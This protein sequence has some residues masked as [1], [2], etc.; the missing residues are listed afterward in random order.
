LLLTWRESSEENLPIELADPVE[1]YR[2][3][4]TGK[5]TALALM[6]LAR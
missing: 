2:L 5:M 6:A 1:A 3:G 4:V